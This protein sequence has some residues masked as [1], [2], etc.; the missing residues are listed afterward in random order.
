M[1]QSR[2]KSHS[3]TPRDGHEQLSEIQFEVSGPE[4]CIRSH[5]RSRAKGRPN[6]DSTRSRPHMAMMTSVQQQS[7]SSTQVHLS[8]LMKPRTISSAAKVYFLYLSI[9]N[10][11]NIFI[12]LSLIIYVRN[13]VDSTPIQLGGLSSEPVPTR[14]SAGEIH[15]VRSVPRHPSRH[16]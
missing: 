6:F 10:H 7:S 9:E 8:S 15:R 13:L 4:V 12:R 14:R 16:D 5:E 11:M 3:S 2:V 1:S